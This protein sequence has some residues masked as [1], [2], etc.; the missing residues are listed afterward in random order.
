ASYQAA[1]KIDPNYQPALKSMVA[2]LYNDRK[3]YDGA[4]PFAKAIVELTP[5]DPEAHFWLAGC[6][7]NKQD[8]EGA[9]RSYQAAVKLD[10]KHDRALGILGPLLRDH[11]KDYAGAIACFKALSDL[12]PN[13]ARAHVG[14]ALSL[15]LKGDFESAISSYRTA[16][17]I[18]PKRA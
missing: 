13:D 6:L 15:E 12:T 18:D 1:L 3:D 14:L 10:P 16:L 11:K 4:V 17:Q 8:V 7:H 2:L 5:N 9:I